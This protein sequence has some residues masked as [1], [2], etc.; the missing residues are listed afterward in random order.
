MSKTGVFEQGG[1]FLVLVNGEKIK[2]TARRDWADQWLARAMKAAGVKKV[3]NVE[4]DAAPR[5]HIN[6]RF[7][8]LDKTVKM[9]AK[10]IQASAVISGSG[11]LGK[12]YAVRKALLDAGLKDITVIRAEE[13]TRVNRAKSF[14]VVKGYSTPKGLYRTLFENNDSV[15]VFDDCDS[16]LKDPVALNLL[17]GA[18]D[19]YDTR[20]ISWNADMRDDDLPRSFIFT[21]RVVFVSNLTQ[22]KIDQ[23]IRTR[24]AVIDVSMSLEEIVDRMR[25]MIDDET[26]MPGY[27][28]NVKNDA[29]SFIDR[30]K[31]QMSELS[32]RTLITV[33]KV[34]ESD[35]SGEWESLAEYL[36]CK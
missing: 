33:C 7:N 9:V 12:S 21:G 36:T 6:Q 18:L 30:C 8:F 31:S 19:S 25:V 13:G 10:G 24:S 29:I 14:V 23:A 26:F 1:K 28:K 5:F 27:S 20:V 15:I 2:L 4:P 32:L 11:G 22:D 35:E 34:R 17:K 16:V 3:T